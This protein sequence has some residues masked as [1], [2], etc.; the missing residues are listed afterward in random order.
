MVTAAIIHTEVDKAL[1]RAAEAILRDIDLTLHAAA[2]IMMHHIV[3]EKRLPFPTDCPYGP[4]TPNELIT[5]NET[6]IAATERGEMRSFETI[7]EL[8]AGLNVGDCG[9]SEDVLRDIGI[10]LPDAIAMMM[11]RIV[12]EK[13]LPFPIECPY[14]PITPNETTIAAMLEAER[15]DLVSFDSMEEFMEWLN[16]DD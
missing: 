15:G 6:A 8:M 11:H 9:E 14:C 7:D 3:L 10:T 4:I 1:I 16:A 12:A 5:P 13:A 2:T